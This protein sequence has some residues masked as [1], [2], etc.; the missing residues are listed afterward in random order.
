MTAPAGYTAQEGPR[1]DDASP[2][3]DNAAAAAASAA[4]EVPRP[5]A[6]PKPSVEVVEADD[7][8]GALFGA[9]AL[10]MSEPSDPAAAAA[11]AVSFVNTAALH[12]LQIN[13]HSNLTIAT[14]H[15]LTTR[16]QAHQTCRQH[17]MQPMQ[18]QW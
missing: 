15:A 14:H 4:A 2:F 10:G 5:A 18:Q 1:Q 7:V 11:V 13:P 8:S 9:A 12:A 17:P 6:L 3:A 16:H